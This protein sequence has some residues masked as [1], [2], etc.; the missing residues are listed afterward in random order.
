M[1]VILQADVK[2][3]GKKGQLVDVSD[4][5]ARNFLLPRKLAVEA[6][7][8]NMNVMKTQQAAKE[9]HIAEEKTNALHLKERLSNA[10]VEIVAK[11]G[12]GGRLFGSVTSKEIAEELFKAEKIEIDKRKIVLDEPIKAFGM[13][14]VDVKLYP[15]IVAELKIRVKE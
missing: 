7:N 10:T 14:T 2:G 12:T 11:A 5:Y 15:E 8:Q 4:G 13:Y 9:H 3:Q 1:K 6:N